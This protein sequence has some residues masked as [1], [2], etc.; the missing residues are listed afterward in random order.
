AA[1]GL[2]TGHVT[3]KLRQFPIKPYPP[4]GVYVE[5]LFIP[6]GKVAFLHEAVEQAL[7]NKLDNVMP[8]PIADL[9][10]KVGFGSLPEV[11]Y[12]HGDGRTQDPNFNPSSTRA[13]LVL[14]FEQGR[15]WIAV[16]QSA[17]ELDGVALG[18]VL[19]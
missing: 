4:L 11:F 12:L 15:G 19:F 1:L 18:Q 7:A 14:D 9:L 13:Y 16:N 3:G 6:W 10:T 2:G 5:E 8:K 17:I